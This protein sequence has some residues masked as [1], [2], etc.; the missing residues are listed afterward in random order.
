MIELS[1]ISKYEWLAKLLLAQTYFQVLQ[2]Q[3]GGCPR[4]LYAVDHDS[5]VPLLLTPTSSI[6]MQE[7][8]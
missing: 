1:Y 2:E 3:S 5:F 6:V 7:R 4:A 8:R